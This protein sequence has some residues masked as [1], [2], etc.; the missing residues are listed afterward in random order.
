MMTKFQGIPRSEKEKIRERAFKLGKKD[1]RNAKNNR[2]RKAPHKLEWYVGRQYDSLCN[3]WLKKNPPISPSIQNTPT[4][5]EEEHAITD[6]S[7]VGHNL[8]EIIQR[9]GLPILDDATKLRGLLL[10][11][12]KGE[13]LLEINVVMEAYEEGIPRKLIA[14][15]NQILYPV[16]RRQLRQQFIENSGLEEHWVDWGIGAWV[17]ALKSV[18][19]QSGT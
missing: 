5:G 1:Y 3:E 17:T 11:Y 4:V 13:D 16:L 19:N 12:S 2:K 14:Q 10:D 9:E 18:P 7:G 6:L 15:S 8:I